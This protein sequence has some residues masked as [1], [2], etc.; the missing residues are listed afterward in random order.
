VDGPPDLPGAEPRQRWRLVVCRAPDAPT[1]TQRELAEAWETAIV[2]SGLPVAM[3][4]A[5]APRPRVSFGAPLQAR[6]AAE[7]ELIDVVLTERVP[8]WRVREALDGRLPEGWSLIDLYDVWLAGPALPGRVVAADYRIVLVA[9]EPEGGALDPGEVRDAVARL[10]AAR[11]VRRERLKGGGSV[12][13]DLR[14]LLVDASV[15]D[16]GP[17]AVLRVRTRFH[18]ELGTGRPEEVVAALGDLVGRS[19]MAS[20]TVRERLVL[21]GGE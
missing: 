1:T 4:D 6:I 18:P 13:Y 20:S 8:T 7:A 10:L 16:G 19:L 21:T 11:S 14:P 3:T 9:A 12:T 2:G 5:A 17:P 15:I